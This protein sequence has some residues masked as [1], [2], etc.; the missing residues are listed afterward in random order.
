MEGLNREEGKK[1]DTKEGIQR[2]SVNTKIH[3]RNHM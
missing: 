3:L 2:R 1:N